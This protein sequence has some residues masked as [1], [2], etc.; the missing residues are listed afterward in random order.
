MPSRLVR[1]V[2]KV[3]EMPV[4]DVRPDTGPGTTGQ[5]VSLRHLQIIAAVEDVYGVSFTPREIRGIRSLAD[6]SEFLRGRD[7]AE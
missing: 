7:V 3:L 2:A 6:L 5:W 4:D 1:L